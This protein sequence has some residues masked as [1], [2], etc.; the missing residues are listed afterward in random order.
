MALNW[1]KQHKQFFSSSEG[2]KNLRQ[3][4]CSYARARSWPYFFS[5]V[6]KGEEEDEVED[7][8]EDKD[9]IGWNML[10]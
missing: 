5:K 6:W 10:I 2:Q 8:D 9:G 3:N 4:Q 1:P 7:E